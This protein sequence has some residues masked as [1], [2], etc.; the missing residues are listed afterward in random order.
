MTNSWQAKLGRAMRAALEWGLPPL[1]VFV[2]VVLVWDWSVRRYEIKNYL[3]PSPGRVAGAV[4]ARWGDLASA[5]AYTGA[6]AACGF[7]L[8][9]TVGTAVGVL[10][11]QSS[12]IRRS[13]YPYAIFLQTV[14]IVAIAQ[15]IIRW[16]GN[17]FV[18]VTM[19]SFLISLFPILSG[20]TTGLLSVDPDLIDL[21]RLN[22]ATR[23]QVL[24]KLRLPGSVPAIVTGAKSSSGLAVVGAIVGEYFAGYSQGRTGLGS[25]ILQTLDQLKMHEVFAAI[26]ASTLLALAIFSLAGFVNDLVL[27]HWFEPPSEHRT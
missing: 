17:G 4:V 5:T 22:K 19:V 6:A 2:L 3:L 13:C 21:F 15:L 24:F 9:L 20:A 12:I 23:W 14:P 1:L 27:R 25:M 11:S 7:L 26:M 18:S 16:F 10:F 8:S